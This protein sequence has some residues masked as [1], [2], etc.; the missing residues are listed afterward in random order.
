MTQ[1]KAY[2][3]GLWWADG[4]MTHHSKD[5]SVPRYFEIAMLDDE[6]LLERIKNQFKT[7]IPIGVDK[8]NGA[9]RLRLCS[10]IICEDILK[11]GGTP[12]KSKNLNIPKI[13]DNYFIS[14][15]RGYF[16]GD[17]GIYKQQKK[18]HLKPY[19]SSSFCCGDNKFIDWL[20]IQIN[21]LDEDIIGRLVEINDK[22]G[23][24]Y[25][26]LYFTEYE[27]YKLG[28]LIYP[29]YTRFYM[30]RKKQIFEELNKI[31]KI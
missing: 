22:R 28:K 16:D 15:L 4:C 29:K 26:N 24:N 31:I 7:N 27:T 12:R 17:G 6:Y 5:K 11:Y 14:F 21:F 20:R 9:K 8:R 10:R 30:K 25:F 2:I 19:Y 18:E 1:N 23:Y 3:L 13:K